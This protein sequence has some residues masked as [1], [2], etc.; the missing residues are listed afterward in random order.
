MNARVTAIVQPFS[1]TVGP[2]PRSASTP[3]ND[4]ESGAPSASC[5]EKSWNTAAASP[6]GAA[7]ST[8]SSLSACQTSSWSAKKSRSPVQA[9]LTVTK[10]CA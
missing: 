4:G 5:R 7:R 2:K 3:K 10:F 1:A 6:T 8:V 9:R